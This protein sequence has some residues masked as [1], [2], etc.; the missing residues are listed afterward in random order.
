[1]KKRRRLYKRLMRSFSLVGVY[2][3]ACLSLRSVDRGN[4]AKQLLKSKEFLIQLAM[5]RDEMH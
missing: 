1:M 2:E 3:Q 4:T 5:R